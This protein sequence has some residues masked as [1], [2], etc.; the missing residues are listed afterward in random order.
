M[1]KLTKTLIL[2]LFLPI[3]LFADAKENSAIYGALTLLPPLVAIVLAFI[4]RN[5][6]FSLFM[7]IFTGTFMVNISGEN[8]FYA[9]FGAFVDMSSKMVGSLAD[10]WNAGIVLQVLT[11]GGM[12]AVVTKM[13]GLKAIS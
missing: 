4:T 3:F 6:I 8:I 5:V 2:G 13:G 7:G 1:S 10:S 12:I 11:I 9:F